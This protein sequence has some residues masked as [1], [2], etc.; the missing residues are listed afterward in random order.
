MNIQNL[1]FDLDGTLVDSSQT[2]SASIKFAL[3]SMDVDAANR[4]PVEA[5]IGASLFDIFRNEFDLTDTQAYVA[6][7]LYREHYDSLNQAGTFVYDH[8]RDVLPRLREAGFRLF[9]AT[10]KPTQIAEKV[11]SDLELRHWFDGVA[12]SSMDSERRDKSSIIA[13]ALRKFDLDPLRSMMIGDRNQDITGARENGLFSMAVTYGFGSR[14]ELH[15]VRPDHTVDGSEE[16]ASLLLNPS[17]VGGGH[18]HDFMA[19]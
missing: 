4:A 18:A 13:H 3:D 7:D 9:I 17:I 15:S 1:L 6:I 14:E 16:I 12:G 10:V 11:L 2:I 19:K 5:V 8:I